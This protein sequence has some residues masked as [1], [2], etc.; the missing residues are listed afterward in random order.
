MTAQVHYEAYRQHRLE[1]IKNNPNHNSDGTV[2]D[3]VTPTPSPVGSIRSQRSSTP[4]SSPQVSA[5]STPKMSNHNQANNNTVLG[6]PP[7]KLPDQNSNSLPP[8]HGKGKTA[9][10]IQ[11]NGGPHHVAESKI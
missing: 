3:M 6:P 9:M 8:G 2:I 4:R 11:K 1:T 5:N 10:M 7:K